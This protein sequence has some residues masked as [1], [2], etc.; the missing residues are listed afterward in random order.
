M[1]TEEINILIQIEAIVCRREGMVAENKWR[2]HLG[3][4]V[5]Y[6]EDNFFGLANELEGL[7]AL[8]RK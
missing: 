3:Q 1:T 7:R 5:A 6:T 2:E 4:S 8:L